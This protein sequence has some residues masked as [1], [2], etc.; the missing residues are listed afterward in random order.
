MPRA[1]RLMATASTVRTLEACRRPCSRPDRGARR[2]WS[3]RA[4]VR[5]GSL[6][7]WGFQ[8]CTIYT[9]DSIGLW[10]QERTDAQLTG[11]FLARLVTHECL[12]AVRI[13]L[14]VLNVQMVFAAVAFDG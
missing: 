4:L 2:G 14:Q 13:V 1:L 9:I 5:G 3:G 11:T 12:L 6:G 10:E 8:F 7:G